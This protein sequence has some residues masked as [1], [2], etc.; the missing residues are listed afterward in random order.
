VDALRHGRALGLAGAAESGRTH[1]A[2]GGG[3][4]VL[5]SLTLAVAAVLDPRSFEDVVVDVVRTG[6]DT[7]T[8]GAIA[9]GLA[10]VRDGVGGIPARW[11]EKLQFRDE[12]LA[13]ADRL[14]EG[15]DLGR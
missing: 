8:N 4:Y 15:A 7:D 2:D 14:A 1:L 10:G 5:D 3:G 13:A 9:G 6:N 12:F 11:L